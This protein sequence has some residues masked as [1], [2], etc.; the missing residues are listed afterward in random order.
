MSSDTDE[1]TPG[2]Q[3]SQAPSLPEPAKAAGVPMAP[4]ESQARARRPW[5][6]FLVMLVVPAALALAGAYV[7]VTGGR[8]AATDNAYLQQTKVTI[9][10][11]VSGSIA[12]VAVGE[13]EAVETGQLIFRFD[14]A[15][16]RVALQQTEAAVAAA[17]LQVEGYRADYRESLA[18]ARSAEESLAFRSKEFVR[19]EQL[20]KSGYA[21]QAKY[22]QARH[23]LQSARGELARARQAAA[24]NL[25]AL[26]GDPNL[27]ADRHP[28]VR[29]AIA[30]RAAAELDLAH[31]S[32]HA[33][34]AGIVTKTGRL[35]PGEYL[36]AGTPV[37]SLV[38]ADDSWVEANF[39]ETDLANMKVGQSATIEFDSYPGRV[40]DARIE[41][42]GAG[43][44]AEFSLLPAQ[45]ATGN[46]VKVVQ[47]VPVR[48]R[49][50]AADSDVVLRTGLSAE[51][52]VDTG[53]TRPLPG[54]FRSALAW[55]GLA[56][57]APPE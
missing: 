50:V 36:A 35:H 39:K 49:L 47:R 38:V 32:V 17:R 6:R 14:E 40:F 9:A 8:Y 52:T 19:Q 26:G 11:E 10:P 54:P 33:A 51:V 21:A 23:D 31:S 57:D 43:T 44:G 48:L 16:F 30:R 34:S 27:P 1:A 4:L 2:L 13:N 42:I 24:S 46:W 28:L 55:S 37:A 12:E 56:E 22:D 53:V 15:P 29:E 5:L 45:N 41:S 25:A 18:E 3:L 7:Y 20:L